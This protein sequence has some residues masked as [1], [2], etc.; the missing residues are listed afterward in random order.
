MV[1]ARALVREELHEAAGVGPG[2]DDVARGRRDG[3]G[4]DELIKGLL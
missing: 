1:R 2:A 3:V 4:V